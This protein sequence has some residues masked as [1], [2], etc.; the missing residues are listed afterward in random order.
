MVI[1]LRAPQLDQRGLP[2]PSLGAELGERDRA[3]D[4]RTLDQLHAEVPQL[5]HLLERLDTGRDEPRSDAGRAGG[6]NRDD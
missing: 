3:T 6:H 2:Q 5:E 1:G 4:D